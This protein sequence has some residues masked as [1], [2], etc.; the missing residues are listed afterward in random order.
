M[1]KHYYL[2]EHAAARKEG[3]GLW[4]GVFIAPSDWRSKNRTAEILGAAN[5][6]TE[7]Q[8]QILLPT[9]IEMPEGYLPIARSCVPNAVAAPTTTSTTTPTTIPTVVAHAKRQHDRRAM[10]DRG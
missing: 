8:K 2:E 6:S 9:S 3:T 1:A 4:R 7:A 5:V 10:P